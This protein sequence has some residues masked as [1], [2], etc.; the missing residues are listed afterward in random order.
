MGFLTDA[1]D[2]FALNVVIPMLG[3]VYWADEGGK[4]PQGYQ[5]GFLCATL[6]GTMVGNIAF[7]IAADMVGRRK[8]YGMELLIVILATL[9]LAMSSRGEKDSLEVVG[10]IITWRCIMG[11]CIGAGY[12]LSVVITSEFAPRR[13][14]ARMMAW[15]FFMQPIRQLLA[16]VLSFVV[17]VSWQVHHI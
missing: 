9:L 8:M 13:H 5:T 11:L 16:N 17:V 4:V 2:I 6:A 15:V 1:Y 7:G 14:R 3:Y 12:P 10:F